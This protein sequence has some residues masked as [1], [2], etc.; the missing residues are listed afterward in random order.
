MKN[1]FE[2][3]QS[4]VVD[5]KELKVLLAYWRFK[6]QKI[7]FTNGCFDIIH[8]G[9]VEYLAK[10]ADF[11]DVLLIGLNSDRSVKGLKGE[12]R[13][14]LNEKGRSLILS[15]FQF[16][17]NIIFFEEETPYE[18]IKMVEPD[19]LVKGGDYKPEDIVGQD[20]VKKRKGAI[21]TIK[22]VDG[23]STTNLIKQ[24]KTLDL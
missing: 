7:V 21:K 6:E 10:A 17:T 23:F 19:V 12:N 18:L 5:K 15:S 16:V 9:H 3:L 14:V 24:I 11:G 13:P 22:F 2:K 4:K 8:P 1:H 20:I